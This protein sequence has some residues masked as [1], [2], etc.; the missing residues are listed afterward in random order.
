[1]PNDIET[2]EFY[3]PQIPPAA[4]PVVGWFRAYAVAMTL[5]YV[6]TAGGGLVM[7]LFRERLVQDDMGPEFWMIY[8]VA[9]LVMGLLFF[10]AFAVGILMPPRPWAW[11]YGIVL[12]A[13][14]MTSCCCIP[15][16][17]PLLILWIKPEAQ[18]Y[19]GRGPLTAPQAPSLPSVPQ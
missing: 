13:L 18:A 16:C 10:V 5:L 8:G 6:L 1:M 2:S 15:A 19:F 12:I 9:L 14:G 17:V 3:P 7:A 11:I 4:P